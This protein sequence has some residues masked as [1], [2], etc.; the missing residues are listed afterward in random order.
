MAVSGDFSTVD[1]CPVGF[2][3]WAHLCALILIIISFFS[4]SWQS[5][6]TADMNKHGPWWW[7]HHRR[8]ILITANKNKKTRWIIYAVWCSTS[9]RHPTGGRGGRGGWGVMHTKSTVIFFY[10]RRCPFTTL[11]QRHTF[12]IIRYLRAGC[13]LCHLQI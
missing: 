13:S 11:Q 4:P 10:G 5:K 9:R 7:H 3:G 8:C 6:W 2:Y 1:F 12:I